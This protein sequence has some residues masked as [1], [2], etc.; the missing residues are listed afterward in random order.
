MKSTVVFCSLFVSVDIAFLLLGIGY[1][2]RVD[3]QPN[4]KVIKAG[5]LF[6]LLAA[7]LAWYCAYA[8]MADDSNSFFI[9]PVFHFPWSEK[10][11][12]ARRNNKTD[13]EAV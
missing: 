13:A 11:R 7:F 4:K 3:G 8:G 12:A 2:R 9:A 10:G 5:G 6:A 1:M